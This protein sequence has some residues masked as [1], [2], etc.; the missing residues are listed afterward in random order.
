MNQTLTFEEKILWIRLALAKG[1]GPITFW[2]LLRKGNDDIRNA[3][4]LANTLA[5][6]AL[7]EKEL[8]AHEK[9]NFHLLTT[10]DES[11]PKNLTQLKDCPPTLSVIGNL[12]LLNKPSISIVGARN[13]SIAGKIFARKIAMELG[14][15]G[16]VIVSGMARG[17]DGTAHEAS[18]PTGSI[19]I[20]AEGAD[21]VYPTENEHLY[22]E[23]E[24]HGTI[25]SEMPLGT[26]IDAALFPRRNR[27]IAGLSHGV[28]LIE[29]AA[30]SGSLITAQYA[31]EFG[32]EIFAVPGW[33][34]DVRTRGC[35]LLI[36][37]GAT[38]TESADDVL[39]SMRRFLPSKIP[40]RILSE[41]SNA[42]YEPPEMTLLKESILSELTSVPVSIEALFQSQECS[43][44][45]LLS[46]ITEL[47][48]A[49]AIRRHPNGNVSVL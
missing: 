15:S 28:V 8:L 24:K 25:V 49:G 23:L 20:L 9:P 42:S 40:Q 16:F 38:L 3:C 7:A 31:L 21:V 6:E 43:L 35:N 39:E 47:E 27:I 37:Q 10:R 14:Q 4:K 45:T 12:A 32:K 36:K 46:V 41:E 26:K 17:I 2:K 11:F 29:A 48:I 19:A 13:A 30:H 44:P 22:K 1:V 18:I 33:P 34:A 5:P